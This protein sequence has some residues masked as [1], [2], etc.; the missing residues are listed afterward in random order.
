MMNKSFGNQQ[1]TCDMT[2]QTYRLGH[3][4]D[5]FSAALHFAVDHGVL[6]LIDAKWS[7]QTEYTYLTVRG[8]R[9][10]IVTWLELIQELV[11]TN[12]AEISMM[13]KLIETQNRKTFQHMLPY[14][15]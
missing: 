7:P 6:R 2:H 1:I 11:P 9:S 8:T 14:N 15:K 12:I 4:S 5:T 10:D 13:I 3:D